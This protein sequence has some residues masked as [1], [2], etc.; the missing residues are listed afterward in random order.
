[1]TIEELLIKFGIDATGAKTG[2]AAVKSELSGVSSA[3]KVHGASTSSAMQQAE[4]S[5]G[6]LGNATSK[7]GTAF[8]VAGGIIAAQ[9]VQSLISFGKNALD[10]VA[11]EDKLNKQT[12]AVIKSTGGAANVTAGQVDSMAKSIM[13]LTGVSDENV[14]EGENMLLTFTNIKNGVGAGNDVFNQATDTLIDMSTALGEDTKNAAIQLGKALNDPIKGVTA[15]QRVGVSFT[16]QQKDQIKTLVDSGKTLEAQKVIL[17][18]LNTEFGGSAKAFGD[19]TAGSFAKIQNSVEELEKS[20]APAVAAFVSIIADDAVPAIGTFAKVISPLTDNLDALGAAGAIIAGIWVATMIPAFLASLPVLAEAAIGVLAVTWP[21]L[22]VGAVVVAVALAFKNNMFGIRDIAQTVGGVVI[23]VAKGIIG[24]FLNLAGTL[25]GVAAAIPGPWQGA[26]QDLQRT[27]DQMRASVDAWGTGTA[28][29]VKDA[30]PA[31]V[32]ASKYSLAGLTDATDAA[33]TAA[34]TEVKKTM[35]DMAKEIRDGRSGI[36][37]AMKQTISDAFDPVINAQE[38]VVAQDKIAA[39]KQALNAR[40]LTAARKH[41]LQLQLTQ[42]QES[43]QNLLAESAQYGD[44]VAQIAKL[45]GE[46]ASQSLADGLKSSDPAVQQQAQATEQAIKDELAKLY[47]PG[48]GA[49][50]WGQTTAQEYA[51]GL[52]SGQGAVKHAAEDMTKA[53]RSI[54]VASSPPGPESPLHNIGDWGLRTGQAYAEGLRSSGPSITEAIKGALGG[55]AQPAQSSRVAAPVY[56]SVTNPKAEPAGMSVQ[57]SLL[58]LRTLG[59]EVP[60]NAP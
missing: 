1:V 56:V 3:A 59:Y 58:R 48:E 22:A 24:T 42:D 2:A 32:D 39:D 57:Q 49:Y 27:V 36:A 10:L 17:K 34:T 40:G 14:K 47:D 44:R 51:N 41:E 13:D 43:Y 52:S 12:A 30:A 53:A 19:S 8:S 20:A 28:Q 7:L 60:G 29:S 18:E 9:G 55:A 16:A 25:V 35:A 38:Q 54:I 4:N 37:T 46:L 45:K 26:A 21:F 11:A 50:A 33:G 15:L 5:V 31:V 23:G 6:S